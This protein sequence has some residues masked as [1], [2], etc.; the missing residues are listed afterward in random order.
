MTTADAAKR[1]AETWKSAWEA[2]DTDAIV[3]L[4]HDDTL[5]STQPFR[6]AYLRRA[7]VREYVGQA[8]GEE[9]AV[10]VWVG[11]P[12]VDGDRA[13][14]EWWATL[15]ENGVERTLA[16]TSVLRFDDGGLVL[17][18]RDTWNQV[19]GLREPPDGWGR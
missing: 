16:G 8:F 13:A 2:Q 17:E 14:I 15:K 3:A 7:G 6:V 12:I 19:D 9:D 4:Y 10:R 5:F 18:Q 1:W 11:S